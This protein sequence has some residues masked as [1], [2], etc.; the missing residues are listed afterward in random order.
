M[1]FRVVEEEMLGIDEN[2]GRGRVNSWD[3]RKRHGKLFLC[4]AH[5]HYMEG[6]TVRITYEPWNNHHFSYYSIVSSVYTNIWL[7]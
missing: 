7:T 4:I 5:D 2:G 6:E 1:K 3:E